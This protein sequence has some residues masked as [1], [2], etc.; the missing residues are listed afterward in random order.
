MI[1]IQPNADDPGLAQMKRNIVE[2]RLPPL[3]RPRKHRQ[4]EKM[5]ADAIQRL[6]ECLIERLFRLG[7]SAIAD[8]RATEKAWERAERCIFI[9]LT[10]H[11]HLSTRQPSLIRGVLPSTVMNL[12]RWQE[13]LYATC[14]TQ[15][16]FG[17]FRRTRGKEITPALA[18]TELDTVGG[19]TLPGRIFPGERSQD[20]WEIGRAHV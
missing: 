6:N 9:K 16:F 4:T 2:Q 5:V 17:M 7:T 1:I 13:Q 3:L 12:R 15:C 18:I 19:I 20:L 8:A 11:I 10:R 14:V